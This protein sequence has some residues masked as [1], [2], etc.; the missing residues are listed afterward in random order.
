[1]TAHN[2]QSFKKFILSRSEDECKVSG[3]GIVAE[4][5]QFS[6]GRCVIS[7]VTATPS[8]AIYENIGDVEIVHGHRGK[9]LIKWID[10]ADR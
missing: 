5:I 10:D 8:I 1:M 9:T 2:P 3:T 4:G 7:W 6:S